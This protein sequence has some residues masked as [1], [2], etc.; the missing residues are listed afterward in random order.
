MVLPEGIT[1]FAE[2]ARDATPPTVDF[3]SFARACHLAARAESGSVERIEPARYPRN[4]HRAILRLGD[5][6]LAVL[7]NAHFP[8]IAFAEASD[9][10]PLR[11]TDAVALSTRFNDAIPCEV[12][13]LSSLETHPDEAVLAGLSDA[14]HEQVRYWQPRR[15]GD[16]I[17][18]LW[19]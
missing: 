4:Y 9:D 12:V 5:A 10:L 13:D 2:R 3:K 7:C 6:T 19:A 1:G 17:F 8:W 18:N 11:F 14:E 15:I 16:I